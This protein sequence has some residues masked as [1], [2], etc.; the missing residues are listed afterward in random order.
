MT[1]TSPQP[2]EADRDQHVRHPGTGHRG[3][4]GDPGQ[5][6]AEPEHSNGALQLH[7]TGPQPAPGPA[8]PPGPVGSER[9]HH[10][11]RTMPRGEPRAVPVR[12]A[13]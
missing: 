6:Q 12:A 13:L 9:R 1:V 4:G 10:P 2:A 8:E 7:K 11:A 5:Q 3:V